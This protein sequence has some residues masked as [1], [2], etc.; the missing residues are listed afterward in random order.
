MLIADAQVHIWTSGTPVHIHR[1]VSHYTE[2]RATAGHGRSRSRPASCC[3]RRAGIVRANE[4]AIEAA[5][6]HPD[7][8]AI[9]GF[10]DV[11]RP[12]NRSLIDTWK[13]QPGMLGLRFAF[14]KPGEENW[15]VD[16][17]MDWLWPAAE[18][19]GPADRAARPRIA[20]KVV[21]E[22]AAKHPGLKLLV[23]H[24]ARPRGSHRRCG[25]GGHRRLARARQVSERR[26]QSDRR[27]ELFE[28]AV[29][30]PQHPQV[31][32]AD[33]RRVRPAAHVLGHR[34]HAHAVHVEAVRHDVHRRAAV[35]QGQ[36]PRARDGPRAVR[37]GSAG[38]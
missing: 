10:F 16:G 4:V 35:A 25:L 14:L 28:R 1:Q 3:T 32:E 7:R 24:M 20:A 23:D 2:G 34:H 27:A 5:K 33:L 17:T 31:P 38:K 29:S 26:D 36:G 18:K 12:E 13:D 15:L 22:I 9:L 21:G 6:Q 11:S 30:V 19:A 8:L 37:L